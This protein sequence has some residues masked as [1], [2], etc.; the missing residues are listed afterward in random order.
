MRYFKGNVTHWFNR[1]NISLG[2][3][4]AISLSHAEKPHADTTGSLSI[5]ANIVEPISLLAVPNNN[6]PTTDISG[7]TDTPDPTVSSYPA[8]SK[9]QFDELA[10]KNSRDLS[11]PSAAFT[12]NLYD[13]DAAPT[14]YFY[15]RELLGR[16]EKRRLT[17]REVVLNIN[18]QEYHL[19]DRIPALTHKTYRVQWHT[20]VEL[21]DVF[22]PGRYEAY[23]SVGFDM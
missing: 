15:P 20:E 14:L 4:F 21:P 23:I 19:D 10:N 12:L 13:G 11:L 6:Q 8:I 2:I 7:T 5:G 22:E 16:S 9:V 18:G 17:V 1:L 3:I